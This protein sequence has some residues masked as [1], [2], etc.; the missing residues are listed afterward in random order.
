MACHPWLPQH[1]PESPP[2]LLSASSNLNTGS[3]TGIIPKQNL[4]GI[5]TTC[6]EI[7]ESCACEGSDE[8]LACFFKCI[9][10]ETESMT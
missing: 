4:L 6:C 9:D 10:L 8:T 3:N 7:E 2:V 5:H 1:L